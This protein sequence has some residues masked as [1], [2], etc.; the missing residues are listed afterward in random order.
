[1]TRSWLLLFLLFAACSSATG[2][3]AFRTNPVTTATI[4][5]STPTQS[6]VATAIPTLQTT[7]TTSPSPESA[8]PESVLPTAETATS[9]SVA[10]TAT[11]VVTPTTTPII[12]S[13]AAYSWGNN[14]PV[15]TPNDAIA[16]AL[17]TSASEVAAYNHVS[18]NLLSPQQP[19]IVPV[20]AG[21]VSQVTGERL[22]IERGNDTSRPMV[23]LT[24][25][26][27]ASAAPT[28]PMLKALRD[29]HLH[30]T[31]FLTGEWMHENPELLREIV[32]DGHEVANHSLNHPDFTKL[33]D[34]A[35]L[36]ELAQTEA[37]AQSIAHTSTRPFFRPPFGAYNKHVLDMVIGAG[38]LPIYWTVDSLDS[39]GQ[40]KSPAFLLERVTHY[41]PREK[42]NGAIFLMHCGSAPSAVA[43]P[44]IL[45]RFAAMGVEVTTIS[46]VLG[47]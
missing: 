12:A 14:L 18:A 32:A 36:D 4:Q 15:G 47:Q 6:P 9:P 23:A 42:L 2:P 41:L 35:I 8:I 39:V 33:D 37:R 46:R 20:H 5:I 34:K 38:Y 40:V 27:G 28:P 10:A 11:T 13:Y 16:R 29:H 31:F 7:L 21:C 45:D 19:V 26:A 24:L 17:C 44:Q 25:D 22:L 1:M 30:I 3:I 43:L